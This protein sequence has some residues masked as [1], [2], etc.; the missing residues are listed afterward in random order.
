[1]SIWQ[2]LTVLI[3]LRCWSSVFTVFCSRLAALQKRRELR[4]AGI[5]IQKKRKKKRVLSTNAEIPFEKRPAQ[6]FYDTSMECTIRCNRTSN[7]C[8]SSI[9]MENSGGERG[10]VKHPPVELQ[11]V[12][13]PG[14]GAFDHSCAFLCI[15]RW[16]I[17]T[18]R[19]RQ[20]IKKKKE[21]DLPSAILQTSGVS[22]FTR[23]EASWCFRH[24]RSE[25]SKLLPLTVVKNHWLMP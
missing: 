5:D 4:A 19:R 15:V 17:V 10:R 22:E 16:R 18:E 25:F 13:C 24:H 6:G 23:R 20:K 3:T 8:A 12:Q 1:M 14:W 7:V 21:S 2:V 9:S 11:V